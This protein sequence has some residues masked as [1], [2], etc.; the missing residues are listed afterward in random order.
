MKYTYDTEFLEDGKTLE[1]I[2]IGM[3]AEDGREYYAINCEAPWFR[4]AKHDWLVANVAKHL[5][6]RASGRWFTE[7]HPHDLDFSHP[8]MGK[9]AEIRTGLL[10]F[11]KDDDRV[12]LWADYG[13]Y[14][15]VVLMQLWG[16]MVNKPAVLPYFTHDL[17]QLAEAHPDVELPPDPADAHNALADAWHVMECLKLLGATE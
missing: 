12:E 6:M 3:V 10:D 4:I 17:Q 9:L 16:P 2:S 7:W 5:P 13:A 1:L 11:F 8:S 15:H 14:D